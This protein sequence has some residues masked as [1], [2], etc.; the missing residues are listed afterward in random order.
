MDVFKA[1]KMNTSKKLRVFFSQSRIYRTHHIVVGYTAGGL[2]MPGWKWEPLEHTHGHGKMPHSERVHS[3][4][5]REQN[6]HI[7]LQL[8][9]LYLLAS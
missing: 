3:A 1:Q 5:T 4:I 9:C 2:C 7:A 8:Q 6:I